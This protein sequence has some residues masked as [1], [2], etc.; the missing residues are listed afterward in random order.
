MHREQFTTIRIAVIIP[1]FNEE[2]AI[3]EVV[4][5][6]KEALP[7]AEIYVFDNA[8]TDRTAE[9][10]LAAGA[11]VIHVGLK[12]KGNVVRR[13]FADTEA[14]VYLMV[15][16]DATY[17]ARA[18]PKLIEKL[19]NEGLDM[20][21][22]CR[23]DKSK[24]AYRKGHR[25]GNRLLTNT[26]MRIF[27]GQFTDMLSGYRAF[28][29]RYAKSFP[30][31]AAGFETETEL[32]VHALEL[33]MPYG[34]VSTNYGERPVG[35]SSKLSTYRDGFRILRSIVKLYMSERP[36]AFFGIIGSAL[37]LLSALCATPVVLEYIETGL[38]PR[39]PLAVLSTGIMLSGL[40]SFVCGFVLDTVT[41]G[42]HEGKRLIYLS[43]PATRWKMGADEKVARELFFFI[44]AGTIG[45]LVDTGVLYLVK[46]Q[47]GLYWGRA[48]S[49]LCAASVTWILNRSRTF[50]VD[51][52]ASRYCASTS[53]ICC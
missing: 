30:A 29:R 25:F 33:R 1:C 24:D 27:N 49:F 23:T 12:G 45:F 4:R 14:D 16:G 43:I 32:T 21:V 41:R 3:E 11:E 6:F 20:V 37:I 8:S 48:I 47:C 42:R 38:V 19:L 50:Q 22:G 35:S 39:L 15:D 34:E 7:T 18:A 53:A 2:V 40:L 5:S 51:T 52:R 13:M 44:F 28:S 9:M 17:D 31:L 46:A 36:F 26:V 10:A